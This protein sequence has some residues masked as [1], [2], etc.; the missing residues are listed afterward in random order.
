MGRTENGGHYFDE[1]GER[2][3]RVGMAKYGGR[4]FDE[5]E[6]GTHEWE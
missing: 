5:G 3:T 4:Y 6:R 1:G 2:E